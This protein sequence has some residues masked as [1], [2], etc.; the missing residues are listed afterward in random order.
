[1]LLLLAAAVSGHWHALAQAVLGGL[2]L[3]G[4]YLRVALISPAGKGLKDVKA[5]ASLG[6]LLA[7]LGWRTMLGRHRRRGSSWPASTA[8]Q[9]RCG[10]S[11]EGQ[12]SRLRTC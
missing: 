8:A 2:A 12:L 11:P 3:T 4:F 9:P 5:A 10:V 1:M 7:W 6:T